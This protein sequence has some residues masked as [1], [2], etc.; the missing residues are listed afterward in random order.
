MGVVFRTVNANWPHTGY[1]Q[2]VVPNAKLTLEK[3]S[4]TWLISLATG[5]Y[6]ALTV[7]RDLMSS[8]QVVP[9]SGL[10]TSTISIIGEL[11]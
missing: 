7:P 4:M 1:F 6:Q 10:K 2:S 9:K 8:R 11:T 3:S 5:D